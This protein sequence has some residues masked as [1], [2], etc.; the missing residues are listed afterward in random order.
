MNDTH[1][2][3]DVE[4]EF[5]HFGETDI[6]NNPFLAQQVAGGTAGTPA[7]DQNVRRF[8]GP[9]L[10]GPGFGGQTFKLPSRD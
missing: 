1:Y 7:N 9:N 4:L 10:G 3:Y 5:G 2:T 8:F 6:F